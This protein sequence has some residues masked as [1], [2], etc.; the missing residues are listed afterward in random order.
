MLVGTHIQVERITPIG[1]IAEVIYRD[2]DT[3]EY[4]VKFFPCSDLVLRRITDPESYIK[5]QF[6]SWEQFFMGDE[7]CQA[8]TDRLAQ[9][10][11]AP[12]KWMQ[13]MLLFSSTNGDHEY[14]HKLAWSEFSDEDSITDQPF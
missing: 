8:L 10:Q 4:A 6:D 5:G 7:C 2:V 11:I 12:E 1:H 3:E 14:N 13:A 9:Y